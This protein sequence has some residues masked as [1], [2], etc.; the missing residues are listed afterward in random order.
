MNRTK[1]LC[2]TC[3]SVWAAYSC[4]QTGPNAAGTTPG[5]GGVTQSTTAN[6]S[7]GADSS[8]AAQTTKETSAEGGEENKATQAE[9][10]SESGS[11]GADAAGG[12]SETQSKGGA[13]STKK[14]T[15]SE[16]KGGSSSVASSASKSSTGGTSS[17]SSAKSSTTAATAGGTTSAT[18]AATTTAGITPADIV[19]DLAA[20]FLWQA[21][22]RGTITP[23]TGQNCPMTEKDTDTSCPSGGINLTQTKSV[24]GEKDKLYT[25]TIE[26]R[27]V[28]GT[29][30]YKDG[31]RASTAAV[32]ESGTNNW[33]YVGGTYANPTGWWNSY[34]LKVEPATGDPSGDIYYFNGSDV[35]GGSWCER[36][37]TY[38][39][40]YNASFKVKGGGTMTFKIH[41]QN[42]KAMQ[43][44][45]SSIDPNAK[46]E[47][48]TVDLSGMTVQPPA[49]FKQPPSNALSKTYYP[50]WMW[51]VA[52]SVTAS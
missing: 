6:G 31:T 7:G 12:E 22:C 45:G 25:V 40:K 20:G 1:L 24:K 14:T 49:S 27:G 50:Q 46:C 21:D 42:C 38:L 43:N 2:L 4:S 23:I 5:A 30:C 29:R 48:R 44:C 16:S 39:V 35:G 47:P 15:N 28:I 52:T 18:T 32:S 13:S 41:D 3:I 8:S 36:E 17:G 26:V 34:E 37:A 33:W 10:G 51:I 11:G 9:G 19:P